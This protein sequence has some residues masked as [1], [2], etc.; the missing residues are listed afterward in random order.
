M[1]CKACQHARRSPHKGGAYRIGCPT[2]WRA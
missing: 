1:S 2:A